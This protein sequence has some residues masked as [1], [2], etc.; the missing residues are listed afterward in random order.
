MF[1]AIRRTIMDDTKWLSLN[2]DA[3]ENLLIERWVFRGVLLVLMLAA[4]ILTTYLGMEGLQTIVERVNVALL[5][6]VSVG[7]GAA[8]FAM[9]NTDIRI[10]RELRRRRRLDAEKS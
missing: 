9:R 1:R 8:V 5:A 6:C 10:H 7:A 3:L 4:A 2:D